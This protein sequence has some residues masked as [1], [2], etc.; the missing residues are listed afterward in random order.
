MAI[1]IAFYFVY[2]YRMSRLRTGAGEAEA[3]S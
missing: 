2:G 3:R 1:G